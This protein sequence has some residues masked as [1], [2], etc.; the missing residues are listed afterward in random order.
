LQKW[1]LFITSNKQKSF[2]TTFRTTSNP[3][4]HDICQTIKAQKI[5][6]TSDLLS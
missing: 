6:E 1:P 3:I 4:Q 5:S 2:I